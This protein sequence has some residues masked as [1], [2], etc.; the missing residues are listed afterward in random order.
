[1]DEI[2]K[3]VHLLQ[4]CSKGNVLS[5]IDQKRI[6]EENGCTLRGVEQIALEHLILPARYQQNSLSCT[7]Q[8]RLFQSRVAIIGCGGL[9]GRTAELLARV[10]IGHLILT[11]PD[12]FSESNLNRQIFCTLETIGQHKVEVV[13][14]ELQ[15]INPSLT[16]TYFSSNF[17]TASITGADIAIDGL[18]STDARK[19]LSKLCQNNNI[20]LIHGAVKEWYGHVGVDHSTNTLIDCLYPQP[21][22][23]TIP[24]P[25]VLPMTVALIAALQV[26]ETCKIILKS[27]S[28][29][30][31]GWLQCDLLFHDYD[32]IT[33]DFS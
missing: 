6:A 2:K 24:S 4:K 3:I 12:I 23:S 28:H 21:Q 31:S 22:N 33:T 18:D 10:G 9:G 26:T 27:V 8:L 14:R 32:Y 17:C 11:D 30:N 29:L 5:F 25:S 7:E 13:A 15:K 16:T 1:M 19:A 20:P